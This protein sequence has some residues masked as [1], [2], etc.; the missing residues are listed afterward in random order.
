MKTRDG[1]VSN[2]SSS[3]FI[4]ALEKPPKNAKDLRS[5][6]W[7]FNDRVKN[8]CSETE[9]KTNIIT[10]RIFKDIRK[11]VPITRWK[12]IYDIMLKGTCY[13]NLMPDSD[14]F[15]SWNEY[16][17]RCKETSKIIAKTFMQ[18]NR[19]KKIYILEYGDNETDLEA[20][21]EHG[22][23][24]DGVRRLWISHH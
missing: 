12:T 20:C 8:E 15:K 1:F 21:I 7:L 6:L 23:V 10:R 3:S 18:N 11:T 2:S 14:D 13:N 4:I 5:M 17:K 22:N 16:D 24:F 9:V 19:K